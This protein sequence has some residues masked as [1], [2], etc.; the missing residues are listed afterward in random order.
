MLRDFFFIF[1]RFISFYLIITTDASI[2]HNDMG[3][4]WISFVHCPLSKK[5]GSI[6]CQTGPFVH[7]LFLKIFFSVHFK[8]NLN[9]LT[10]T[11]YV[12]FED[13]RILTLFSDY[14]WSLKVLILNQHF[15]THFNYPWYLVANVLNFLSFFNM[16]NLYA[17][18]P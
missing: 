8:S 6:G 13:P 9:F 3:W 15:P 2:T 4:Q 11:W 12:K 14:S 16:F 18:W 5:D 10:V 1:R 7:E 17:D